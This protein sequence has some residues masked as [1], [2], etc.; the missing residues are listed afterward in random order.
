MKRFCALTGVLSTLVVMALIGCETMFEPDSSGAGDGDF[1]VVGTANTAGTDAGGSFAEVGGDVVDKRPE[2]EEV[3]EE[4]EETA[5][6]F[7][8]IQID[9][10]REDTAGPK[11]VLPHDMDNDGLVDLVTGWN[12]SQPVQ[13]HLQRR[14]AEGD[15]S[16]VSVNLG[17]TAPIALIG[18]LAVADFDVDGWLDVAVLV[19]TTGAAPICPTPGEAEPFEVLANTDEGEVEILF[20]PGTFEDITDGDAWQEVRLDRSRFPGRRDVDI[21]EARTLPEWNSYTGIAAGELDGIN[22]PDIVVTF[23]PATCEFYGDDPPINRVLLYFN[24]GGVNTR[25]PGTVPLSVTADAGEDVAVP[26]PDPGSPDPQGTE[27]V[28]NGLGSFSSV[29]SGVGY[30]WEQVAGPPVDLAGATSPNPTFTAPI[31]S[32][33]LTFRL[34]VGLGGAVDF[35]YVN[36]VAGTPP[37]LPPV[38]VSNGDQTVLPDADDPAATIVEIP[39]Y[40]AEPDGDALTY[41]WT[42]MSGPPV[43]LMN[44]TTAMPSFEAPEQG[45]ELRFRVTVSDGTFFDSALVV[46]TSGVWAPIWLDTSMARAGDVLI[47]DVDLDGD[48]DVIYTF[49]NQITSDVTWA[50]NPRIPHDALS[51]SGPSAAHQPYEWQIRPVGH[52]DTEADIIT[53]G[54]I[55]LDGF[56]DVLVR[57]WTG[58]IVQWFRHPGAA[59]LEPIFPPPDVVPDRF[60]FPWQVYTMAEYEFHRPAG[61]AIGDLTGDGFNEVAIAAGGVVSWYDSALAESVYHPWGEN[62][63]IDDT[64]ANGTTDDP[65]DPDFVDAGT[66]MNML[67]IVDIDDD[68]FGDV[69]GTLDRRTLSGLNDDTLI[70][71]RNTLGDQAEELE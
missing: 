24:P 44:A 69:I 57:S 29:Y 28:L 37:T 65:S 20:S 40:A 25:D 56:D 31:T 36:V 64:K 32:A 39:V 22:G 62:F 55:D 27:V 2:E 49:P 41:T 60:N 23:N 38:V 42:Q 4:G 61:I 11:F 10:V 67:T 6:N 66:V 47:T 5:S 17:G 30:L 21:P 58:M 53:L 3:V 45:G 18:D 63:V 43:V 12:Q 35:D 52:V 46:V 34:T 54:D 68:G 9:P 26:V 16:F 50:R 14:D 70:W 7:R 59:D 13:L 71:F 15:V 51:A 48:N 33:A 1:T 8:A 19:K